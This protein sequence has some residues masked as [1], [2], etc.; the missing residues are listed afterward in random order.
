ME[1]CCCKVKMI[2]SSLVDSDLDANAMGVHLEEELF[3]FNLVRIKL[4][5]VLESDLHD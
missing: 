3:E 1:L 5:I 2:A 4:A